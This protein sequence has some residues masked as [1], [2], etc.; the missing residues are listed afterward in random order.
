MADLWQRVEWKG[1]KATPRLG[2]VWVAACTKSSIEIATRLLQC[3][4]EQMLRS[5]VCLF[6]RSLHI[7]GETCFPLKIVTSC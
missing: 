5:Y 2:S 3:P 4:E 7:L 1:E 6:V